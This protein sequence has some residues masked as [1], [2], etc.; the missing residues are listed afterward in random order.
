[1]NN[2]GFP[3]FLILFLTFLFIWNH[4]L[5]KRQKAHQA[6]KEA[7]WGKER[8]SLVVRKKDIPAE[9]YFHPDISCL[10]FPDLALDAASK[11]KYEA[12]KKQ[13]HDSLSLP[14]LSFHDMS[15]TDLRLTFGT[16]N[17]PVITQAEENYEAFLNFLYEY[18]TLMKQHG[19]NSEAIAALEE[20]IRLKSD[21]CQHYFLLGELYQAESDREAL[22]VLIALA[23]DMTSASKQRILNHLT[24]L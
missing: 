1:M 14:M 12:L 4:N 9:L 16:A 21:I 13:L 10:S 17:Q 6:N 23:K 2:I 3:S 8:Q 20:A 18:A 7:F 19:K 15:N 5:Q 24:K 22:D 11:I